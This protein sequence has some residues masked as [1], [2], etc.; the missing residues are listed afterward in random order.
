LLHD[1]LQATP[2][3]AVNL[4]NRQNLGSGVFT[5][6]VRTGQPHT[7]VSSQ[8]ETIPARQAHVAHK[9]AGSDRECPPRTSHTPDSVSVHVGPSVLLSQIDDAAGAVG[10]ARRIRREHYRE[11]HAAH[12][13]VA[14]EDAPLRSKAAAHDA[15]PLE[16]APLRS[17]AAAHDAVA[18]E[19]AARRSRAAA[20]AAVALEDAARRSR[21]A[22]YGSVPS[23]GAAS[24][25]RVVAQVAALG[26]HV[27]EVRPFTLVDA[28]RPH[29]L[30]RHAFK[31]MWP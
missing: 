6:G 2:A 30:M 16:D 20:H 11:R 29:Q 18:L 31:K 27:H 23:G 19:D 14:L 8:V 5:Q 9:G 1:Q 25:A 17:Q 12:D 21:I 3:E 26:G 13:V 22:A 28:A 10:G 24:R 7:S 15:V 4:G